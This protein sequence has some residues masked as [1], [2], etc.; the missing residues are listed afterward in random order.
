MRLHRFIGSFEL[1]QKT[2]VI[3]D[4]DLLNQWRNV[5]RLENGDQL[6][7]SDGQGSEATATIIESDKKAITL[8]IEETVVP[9]REPKKAVTLY[10]ALLK[11]ENFELVCQKAT[12]IGI[13]RIVPVLSERTIKTGFNRVRLEKIISEACEQSGRTTIP[14]LAEPMKFAEAIEYACG[15]ASVFFDLSGKEGI[16]MKGISNIFIGPEGGWSEGEV[17][18]AKSSD[19]TIASLGKLTMRGE[20]AAIVAS[21]L[22]TR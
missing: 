8:S 4:K 15:P 6:T 9:N 18:L 21:F 13:A 20:T 12:E 17:S 7:L 16:E 19:A 10:C 2:L 1:S 14:E 3:S 11:R 5:L 22:A